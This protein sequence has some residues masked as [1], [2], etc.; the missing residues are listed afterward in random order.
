MAEKKKKKNAVTIV[1]RQLLG[2]LPG[3]RQQNSNSAHAK[4]CEILK[5]LASLLLCVL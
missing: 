3:I 4:L 5:N 2:P 1:K